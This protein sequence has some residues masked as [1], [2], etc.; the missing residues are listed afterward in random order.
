MRKII[1]LIVAIFVMALFADIAK[2]QTSD[3]L[4]PI[5]FVNAVGVP[6]KTNF[7]IDN[8]SVKP[9]GFTEGG[10]ASSFGIQAG[11]HQF[12]L[13]NG[14]CEKLLT[15]VNVK[16]RTSPLYVLYKVSI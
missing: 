8:Q 14:N 11:G 2:A 4:V 15:T 5:G 10:Y 7:T 12:T 13:T 6:T 9:V 16:E 3:S 1:N